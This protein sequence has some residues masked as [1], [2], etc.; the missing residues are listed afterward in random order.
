MESFYYQYETIVFIDDNVEDNSNIL[1]MDYF[2]FI[3]G[4]PY[5]YPRVNCDYY[6]FDND[7]NLIIFLKNNPFDYIL[8]FNFEFPLAS[9]TT[10]FSKIELEPNTYL[11]KINN[12]AI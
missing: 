3:L 8:I 7:E 5:L 9:N 2:V 11:L 1:I 6:V 10:L 12:E 4:Q